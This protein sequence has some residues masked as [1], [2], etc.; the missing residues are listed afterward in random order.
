M[1]ARTEHH[2][3]GNRTMVNKKLKEKKEEEGRGRER[4]EAGTEGSTGILPHA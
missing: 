2:L 1:S 4:R 3:M